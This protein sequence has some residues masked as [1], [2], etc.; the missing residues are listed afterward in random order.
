MTTPGIRAAYENVLIAKKALLA[1]VR[2]AGPEPVEDWPLRTPDDEPVSLSE[3]FGDQTELLV[4]H[5]MGRGCNYCTLWADGFRGYA[6]QIQRRCAFVLCSHDEPGVVKAFAAERGWQYRCV[7]GAGSGFGAAMGYVDDA[8]R[9]HPGVS[10]FHKDP[11]GAIV[12]TGHMPFGPG[13]D[14]CP[15]W[16]FFDL[17]EGG[18][19]DY[20]PK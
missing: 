12:R 19:K 2:A 14:F 18:K 8:G 5:N 15:V 20:Q 17:L 9:P 13:D 7:S 3:L 1:A 6:E 11:D 16:P 4:I 10:A